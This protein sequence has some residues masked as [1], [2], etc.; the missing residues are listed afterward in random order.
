M[1]IIKILIISFLIILI[2][3][4]IINAEGAGGSCEPDGS[5]KCEGIMYYFCDGVVW[6]MGL[7]CND[8]NPCTTDTCDASTSTGCVNTLKDCDDY[9]VCTADSCNSGTGACVHTNDAEN[10]DICS[11]VPYKICVDGACVNTDSYYACATTH[12]GGTPLGC[13]LTNCMEGI[14]CKNNEECMEYYSPDGLPL[15]G[16]GGLKLCHSCV[17]NNPTCCTKARGQRGEKDA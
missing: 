4:L 14:T 8:G 10:G 9:N 12:T 17:E 13:E 16:E 15:S 7:S 1:K 5:T 11:I 3:S 6:S 2:N